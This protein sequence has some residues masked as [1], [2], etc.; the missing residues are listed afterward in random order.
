MHAFQKCQP[1]FICGAFL[2]SSPVTNRKI[3]SGI[4]ESGLRFA[5]QQL[6]EI[7][8]LGY[9]LGA[10]PWWLRRESRGK[11]Y[12]GHLDTTTTSIL[13]CLEIA[14][15]T[16][17]STC[18][19]Q[20]HLTEFSFLADLRYICLFQRPGS[21]E[22]KELLAAL[23]SWKLPIVLVPFCELGF[24]KVRFQL[25]VWSPWKCGLLTLLKKLSLRSIK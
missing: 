22:Q 17:F 13:K 3:P 16:F 10:L 6:E 1:N 19:C 11:S 20:L 24:F 4:L 23:Q 15:Y 2:T 25:W 9:M 12:I 8:V 21:L 7:V 14:D 18:S 5:Y